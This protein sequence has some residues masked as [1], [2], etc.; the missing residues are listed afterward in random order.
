M[1]FTMC[2]EGRVE[3]EE[4]AGAFE[5]VPGEVEFFHCMH[6]FHPTISLLIPRSGGQGW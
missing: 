5:S 6:F 2:D 1:A 4:G 3:A